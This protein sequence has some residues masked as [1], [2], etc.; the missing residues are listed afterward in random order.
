MG[1]SVGVTLVAA[2][3]AAWAGATVAYLGVMMLASADRAAALPW[4]VLAALLGLIALAAWGARRLTRW[5]PAPW[6]AIGAAAL[7][8]ALRLS[9]WT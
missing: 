5:P 7:A 9:P 4:L 8:A 2:A 1:R 3:L 6:L